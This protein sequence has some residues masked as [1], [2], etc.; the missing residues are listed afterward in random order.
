MKKRQS[1]FRES[2]TLGPG[3]IFI[4]GGDGFAMADLALPLYHDLDGGSQTA[5]TDQNIVNLGTAGSED[6]FRGTDGTVEASFDTLVQEFGDGDAIWVGGASRHNT[7]PNLN[8]IGT[9][10]EGTTL[11]VFA[12]ISPA[13]SPLSIGQ[14]KLVVSDTWTNNYF[15]LG[16][17]ATQMS[18]WV[19]GNTVTLTPTGGL[20]GFPA[21]HLVIAEYTGGVAKIWTDRNG[22]EDVDAASN[23]ITVWT[24]P[25]DPAIIDVYH[26]RGSGATYGSGSLSACGIRA[27]PFTRNERI[28]I[29]N[30]FNARGA[31]HT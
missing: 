13:P 27:T 10:L 11:A 7:F 8:S 1:H 4:P 22:F 26:H 5:D 9:I 28:N 17:N 29:Y 20:T 19:N 24:P 15:A 16:N 12:V 30:F 18:F 14:N 2:W 23:T 21:R 31:I 3:G 6:G 25:G